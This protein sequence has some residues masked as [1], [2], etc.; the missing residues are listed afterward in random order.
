MDSLLREAGLTY[1]LAEVDGVFELL[2]EH[3]P[4][5]VAGHLEEEE[6]G[7]ALWQK[8]VWRVVLVHYLGRGKAEK[9]FGHIQIR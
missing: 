2:P 5:R 8:A 6:A 9:R 3:V 1:G 4:A 7:V